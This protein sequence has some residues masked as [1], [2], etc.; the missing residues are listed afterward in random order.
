MVEDLSA[1]ISRTYLRGGRYA[2]CSTSGETVLY[3]RVVELLHT[4]KY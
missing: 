2:Y 3:M 1:I 4:S